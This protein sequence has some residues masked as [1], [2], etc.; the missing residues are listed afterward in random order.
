LVDRIRGEVPDLDRVVERALRPSVV[1]EDSALALDE[2]R[3][4][5]H[6]V[7]NVYTMNLVPDK[8]AGLLATLPELWSQVRAELLAFAEFLTQLA[9][10]DVEDG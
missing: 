1:D 7:R 3:R 2:F 4:F 5:R 9:R 8:M 10:A 6:L